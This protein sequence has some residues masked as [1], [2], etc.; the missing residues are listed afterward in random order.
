MSSLFRKPDGSDTP[1][2][3]ALREL[4]RAD[5]KEVMVQVEVDRER[6]AAAVKIYSLGLSYLSNV[7]P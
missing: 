3:S 5:A 1:E 6:H 4:Q 2:A 7:H